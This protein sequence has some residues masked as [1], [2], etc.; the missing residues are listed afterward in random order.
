MGGMIQGPF[1]LFLV[2]SGFQM[3]GCWQA[4]LNELEVQDRLERSATQV[5]LDAICVVVSRGGY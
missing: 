2:S 4:A 3:P 1:H 5:S